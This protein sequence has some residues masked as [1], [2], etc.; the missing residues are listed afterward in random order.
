MPAASAGTP[1]V[2]PANTTAWSVPS[3]I[4][5]AA[6]GGTRKSDR[7]YAQYHVTSGS[8]RVSIPTTICARKPT[9]P[10]TP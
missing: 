7:S 1:I 4:V 5:S 10:N 9:S 6:A 2:H 8:R 3:R